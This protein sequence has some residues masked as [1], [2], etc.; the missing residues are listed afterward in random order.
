MKVIILIAVAV[1]LVGCSAQGDWV[2]APLEYTCTAEQA[3][4]VDYETKTCAGNTEQTGFNQ[5]YCYAS[6][7]IRDCTKKVNV[8]VKP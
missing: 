8:A 6:A 2:N 3:K 7:L 1:L 5:A 4:K